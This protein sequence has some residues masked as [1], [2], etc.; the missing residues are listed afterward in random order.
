M[1]GRHRQV[2]ARALEVAPR[3]CRS[4]RWAGG[5]GTPDQRQTGTEAAPEPAPP[6]WRPMKRARRSGSGAATPPST[7]PADA[8]SHTTVGRRISSLAGCCPPERRLASTRN[9]HQ[10]P[11]GGHLPRRAYVPGEVARSACAIARLSLV[12]PDSSTE[13]RGRQRDGRFGRARALWPLLNTL[14]RRDLHPRE[15]LDLR[16]HRRPWRVPSEAQRTHST[17]ASYRGIRSLC[18]SAMSED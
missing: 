13:L 3:L 15:S 12:G 10:C 1:P 14:A 6:R 17:A 2:H 7:R 4:V 16:L 11:P 5:L 8:V 9:G 18:P